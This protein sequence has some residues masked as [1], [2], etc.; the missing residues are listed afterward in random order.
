MPSIC[1]DLSADELVAGISN[2]A[3][4]WTAPEP[5]RKR[6]RQSLKDKF[7]TRI[8]GRRAAKSFCAKVVKLF[9][10]PCLLKKDIFA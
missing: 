8:V 9:E 7:G 1:L 4:V 6:E 3:K 2:R 5:Q 10:F